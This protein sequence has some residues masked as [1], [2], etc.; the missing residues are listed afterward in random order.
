MKTTL[1]DD[2]LRFNENMTKLK[3]EINTIDYNTLNES[4]CTTLA[5]DLNRIKTKLFIVI[6]PFS[7]KEKERELRHWDLWGPFLICLLLGFILMIKGSSPTIVIVTVFTIFWIGSCI[8]TINTTL[9][10]G[11]I[12]YLQCMCLIG[13]CIFP[14]TLGALLNK[15]FLSF[16]PGYVKIIIAAFSFLWSIKASTSFL[17][18]SIPDNKKKLA[19]YPI[20]LFYLFMTWFIK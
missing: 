20:F 17:T 13:Y 11:E 10:G 3:T 2:D 8:I 14:I 7:S 4:I 5:R 1:L 12:S 15:V 9:L 6:V 19:L 18:A 16:L